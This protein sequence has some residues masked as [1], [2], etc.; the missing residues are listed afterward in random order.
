MLAGRCE[1]EA[2]YKVEQMQAYD[3]REI[4]KFSTALSCAQRPCMVG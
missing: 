4:S 3:H 2:F 1:M